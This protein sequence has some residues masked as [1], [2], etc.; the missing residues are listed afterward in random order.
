VTGKR[1]AGRAQTTAA[2]VRLARKQ[3]ESKGAVNLSLREIARDLGMASSAIY[4]YFDSRDQLL[5]VLII[6]A[7]DQLGATAEAA[8]AD[9]DRDDLMGRWTA[10]ARS[11]RTWAIANRADF[12][13]VFGTPVPGYE[14]PDDTV[15]P[16]MRY[17]NVLVRLVADAHSAGCT[18]TIPAPRTR[19]IVG[20]YRFVRRSIGVDV[21]DATLLAGLAAWDALFGAI[22]VEVFGHMDTVFAD[23]G[24]HFAA[25]TDM[26]GR[27]L[28]GLD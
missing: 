26:L 17:R 9:C 12:G 19:G 1:A 11:L 21:P 5:T 20:E 15:A 24:A 3:V 7:F 14:A 28:L 8:D 4:R 16:A 23:P 25:L 27:H 2:I 22:S 6:D 18:T 13:L 10:I